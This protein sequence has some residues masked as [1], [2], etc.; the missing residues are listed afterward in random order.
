MAEKLEEKELKALS[1]R[2]TNIGKAYSD[3][4]DR[5]SYR[6]TGSSNDRR[7]ELA[8]LSA[9][10]DEII[11][12]E[13]SSLTK[14]AG[15]DLSDFIFKLFN[16]TKNPGQNYMGGNIR[17]ME[18]L[19]KADDSTMVNYFVS[20]QKESRVLYNELDMIST[21]LYELKECI[22]VTR[23]SIV[24][25]DDISKTI[26]RQISFSGYGEEELE[27]SSALKQIEGMEKKFKLF[28]KIK[29]FV[30]PNTLRYGVYYAY[31]IPYSK[32]F[33]QYYKKKNEIQ[34][35]ATN[36]AYTV[37]HILK[38]KNKDT[39]TEMS[40]SLTESISLV[41]NE[42]DAKIAV[43]K[44]S[45]TTEISTTVEQYLNNI[46]IYNDE[47]P[48]P[49]MEDGLEVAEMIDF[50]VATKKAIKDAEKRNSVGHKLQY[51]DGVKNNSKDTNFDFI[52]N[53]VYVKYIS[54]DRMIPVKILDTTIGYYYVID[55]GEDTLQPFSNTIKIIDAAMINKQT[56]DMFIQQL[57]NKIVQAFDKP[58]LQNNQK[59]RDLILNSLMYEDSYR[60][61]LRFQFI[62]VDYVTEFTVNEDENGNGQSVLKDSLFYAKL[63]LSLLIFK[64]LQILTKSSDTRVYYVKN[65]GLDADIMSGIQNAARQVKAKQINYYDIMN[66]ITSTS[67]LGNNNEIFIPY[68]RSQEKGMEFDIL[69]GQEVQLNNDLMDMLR[70]GYINAT[71]VPSV[72]MQYINEADYAKTLVMA[73]SK[74]TGRVISLQN[75]FNVSITEFYRKLAKFS[76]DLDESII[77]S[78]EFVF[79]APKTINTQ[80]MNDLAQGTDQVVQYMIATYMGQ[81]ADVGEDGNKLKDRLTRKLSKMMLPTLPWDDLKDMA[82]EV[83]AEIQKEKLEAK[84]KNG[85]D[86]DEP[87]IPTF[88]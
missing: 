82:E 13:M 10:V 25:S 69:Q 14:Y 33:E 66:P 85:E 78:M 6:T 44:K 48:L 76:T 35:G 19:F 59:F 28:K 52:S 72:I 57:T 77:D 24:T 65:S 79:V 81:N 34:F 8:Q 41:V 32:L 39:V 36:E 83:Y 27:E 31:T 62:P 53:D 51:S 63:Y 11:N 3:L 20:K 2:V 54:P 7:K 30:V 42:S 74:Y 49:L 73:N 68:G 67:K 17:S 86:S 21:Q 55:L 12:D 75:D 88:V 29:N 5:I 40:A 71:G 16:D 84:N 56:E 1:K 87:A 26:S 70:Q 60:K 61:K 23:D 43:P 46:E 58:F 50:R 37:S 45:T 22:N 47:I 38:E 15:E 4:M 64:M 9:K 80:N 18:D